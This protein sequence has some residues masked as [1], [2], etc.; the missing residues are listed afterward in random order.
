MAP[1][2]VAC[3]LSLSVLFVSIVISNVSS[4]LVYDS[5]TLLDPCLSAKDLVKLDPD[6]DGHTTFQPFHLPGIPAHLH[7]THAPLPWAKRRRYWCRRGKYSSQ[8]V[9]LKARSALSEAP[10]SLGFDASTEICKKNVSFFSTDK[11]MST[12]AC[13][14][15]PSYDPSAPLHPSPV[16]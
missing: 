11:I 9:K 8:L 5:Q 3:R 13:I 2:C 7:C 14:S 12:R 1:V 4:L 15:Q 10:K 6:H 16:C